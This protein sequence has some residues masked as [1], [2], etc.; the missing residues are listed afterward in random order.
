MGCRHRRV[1]KAVAAIKSARA[2]GDRDAVRQAVD[3]GKRLNPG[4]R[5]SERALRG[6]IGAGSSRPAVRPRIVAN[7]ED[8][9]DDFPCVGGPRVTSGGFATVAETRGTALRDRERRSNGEHDV[10]D[11]IPERNFSPAT[12]TVQVIMPDGWS[13]VARMDENV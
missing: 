10:R 7:D 9:E 11:G 2:S 6:A 3:R 12:Q 13:C 4:P 8:G 5:D 1:K